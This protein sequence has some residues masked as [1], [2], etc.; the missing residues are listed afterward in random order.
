MIIDTHAHLYYPELKDRLDEVINRALDNGIEKIIIPAVDIKTSEE[1]L[2]ISEKYN[3]IYSAVGIHPTEVKNSEINHL[4]IVEGFLKHPKVVAIGEIGLDYYWDKNN[5]DEQKHFFVEQIN[6]ANENN[7]PIIIHTRNSI[8]D[9]IKIIENPAFSNVKGQFHCFSGNSENLSKI[10]SRN[11][12]YVSFCGNITYKNYKNIDLIK[13]LNP[14]YLLFETD[15]PFMSPVPIK[16]KTNEPS[17]I[18][19]TIKKLSELMNNEY[20]KLIDIVYKNTYKL[21]TKLK[22]ENTDNLI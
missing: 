17:N 19:H 21:F 8:E 16:G 15:S 18:L 12:L 9:A 22:G 13:S 5:I 10:I 3:Q 4:N 2:N 14:E 6:L 11:N 20:N 7:L 1:I